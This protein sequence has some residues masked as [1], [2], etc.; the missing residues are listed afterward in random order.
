M[1]SGFAPTPSACS[2]LGW[3]EMHVRQHDEGMYSWREN[4]M[5]YRATAL[6][7]LGSS[8]LESAVLSENGMEE[9][10]CSR[11]EST[12]MTRDDASDAFLAFDVVSEKGIRTKR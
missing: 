1:V 8:S 4:G 7:S 11:S 9:R 12:D 10:T 5:A 2:R 3:P 6:A